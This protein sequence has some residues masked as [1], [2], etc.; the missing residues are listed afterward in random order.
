MIN[1]FNESKLHLK[2]KNLYALEYNGKTEVKFDDSPWIFDVIAEDGSAIEIQTANISAL[3]EKCEYMLEKGKKV[4]IVHPV[5]V[6][7]TIEMIESSGNILY[8]KKSPKKDFFL[9][10]LRGMTKLCSILPNENCIIEVLYVKITETR[11]KTDGKVQLSNRSRRH[12]RD[13]THDE[14][15]LDEIIGKDVLKT[16]NDWLNL[17]PKGVREKEFRLCELEKSLM[18]SKSK[19]EAK[20]ASLLVWTLLKMNILEISRTQGR[21]KYYRRKSF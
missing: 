2:L 16:K 1:T 9:S 3:K 7:K 10:S 6:E 13:W 5:A 21:S 14:K 20:W 17:L 19:K 12:L 18:E 15:R 4:R 8:S 11:R